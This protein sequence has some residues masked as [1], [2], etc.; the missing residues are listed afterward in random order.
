MASVDRL[1][2]E[3]FTYLQ[4]SYSHYSKLNLRLKSIMS[5]L[6]VIILAAG[7]GTRMKSQKAKVLHDVFFRPMLCHVVET[8]LQLKPHTISVIIGHQHQEV[9]QILQPYPVQTVLQEQQLGTGHAVLMAEQTCA[10]EK[11]TVMILCGDTPLIRR[12]ILAEMYAKHC[13]QHSAC[14]LMTTFLENPTNYGRVVSDD[15]NQ[16]LAI[17]E[18]KDATESE[19]KIKEINAGIYCVQTELLFPA[20]HTLT[21]NNAQGE[22]Y[23]TDIVKKFV[24]ADMQ[25]DKFI[26]PHPLDVL[27]VNSR[28]ELSEAHHELKMRRNHEIQLAGVTLHSPETTSVSPESSIGMDTLLEANVQVFGAS[29]LG[30]NCLIR[31]GAILTNCTVGDSAVIGPYAVLENCTVSS[32]QHIS[33]H[34]VHNT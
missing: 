19:K 22:F 10:S 28:I 24:E 8:V 2:A 34:T 31:Q 33:A 20:L 7:K 27:G 29:T 25:V 3:L 30:K 21:S 14:T 13:Q 26:C 23:L 17:V 1:H 32:G 6:S 4:K 15:T 5:S 12:E 16:V 9:A 18:Q 11:G